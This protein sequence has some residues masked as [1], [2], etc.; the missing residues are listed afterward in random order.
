MHFE[1][2]YISKGK[3]HATLDETMSHPGYTKCIVPFSVQNMRKGQRVYYIYI[4][5]AHLALL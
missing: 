4:I 5:L 3:Q 2:V 1:F